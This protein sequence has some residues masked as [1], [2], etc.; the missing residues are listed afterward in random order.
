MDFG[1][2]IVVIDFVGVCFVGS[3]GFFIGS[4]DED[5][6]CFVSVVRKV[7]GIVNYLV[8]FFGVDVEMDSYI[9]GFVEFG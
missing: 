7:D 8:G 6:C 5:L 2:E 3:F 9:D 1:D 4:K